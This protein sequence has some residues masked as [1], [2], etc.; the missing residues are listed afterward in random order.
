MLRYCFRPLALL[1]ILPLLFLAGQLSGQQEQADPLPSWN[2][3]PAKKAILEFV[4]VTTNKDDPK[5]VP[6]GERVATFDEDGTTW[7]EHPMYTEVVFSLDRLVEL[8]PRHPEW[9]DKQ[10]FKAV[11]DKDRETME[12]FTTDDLTQIVVAT[13]TDV[14]TREFDQAAREWL[15][16]AKHPRF[17]R[18]YT[19]LAYLPMLEV[20]RYLRANGFKTYIVTGGTQPFVRAFGE[21]T[22]GIPPEQ[23][24]G[25]T[26][27]TIFKP[28]KDGNSLTLDPK[29]LLNNNY[30]GKAND[31]YLFTGRRPRAAFG[32][33]A[34]DQEM[35]E[36]TTAGQGARL[37]M[38]VL[39]DDAK[40]EYAYGPANGLPNT[41]VGAFSQ[42][43][44]DY[45][46]KSGWTVISMK[47]DWKRLFSFDE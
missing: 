3:G 32:N 46:N 19:E 7:V 40:R 34:G 18:L 38:L 45:A 30:A 31:I 22:Y 29:L 47:D 43:L 1:A 20:M 12:K 8:A 33:T 9:K 39:H 11:L 10:P 44:Y 37:G 16:N 25:T 28:T 6:P 23:I 27:K 24:V 35:L 42:A 13:H 17:K 4:H 21:P 5:F 14:T 2:D 41:R 36:Y 26:V 15:G